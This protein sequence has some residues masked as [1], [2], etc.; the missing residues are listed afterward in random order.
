[1]KFAEFVFFSTLEYMAY[2][3]LILVLFRFNLRGNILKFGVFSIVL[4]FVSNTMQL[5]SLSS[6]S[7]LVHLAL[8]I[9][10]FVF[11]LRI[12]ILNASIMVITGYVINFTIS[13][14]IVMTPMVLGLT[15]DAMP[16]ST[17]AY[18]MQTASAFL[19][20]VFGL[21][22]YLQKSGFSFID[23][24]S[25]LD[26]TKIFVKENMMFIIFFSLS[27]AVTFFANLIFIFSSN[28]PFWLITILLLIAL[29]G[30]I[31]SSVKRDVRVHD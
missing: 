17:N 31:Y 30:L 3:C 18:I 24:Y 16:Y 10:F 6:I 9:S 21:L 28:P 5:E 11:F 22:T 2:Y 15:I 29:F 12:H 14:M 27:V 13:W 23:N 8:H 1:M 7:P 20:F 4:S 25:R 26:R 19:M